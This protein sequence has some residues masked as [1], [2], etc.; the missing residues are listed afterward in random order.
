MIKAKQEL[1]NVKLF[2][3]IMVLGVLFF[4]LP[5]RAD[6]V[7]EVEPNDDREEALTIQAN[8]ETIAGAINGTYAGQHVVRG[9][10]SINDRDWFKVYL[11]KGTNYI[12]CNGFTFDY[13]IE[14]ENGMTI[15]YDTYKEGGFGPKAYEFDVLT[16]GDYYICITGTVNSPEQYLFLIG[17][18]TYSVGFCEMNCEQGTIEMQ[19][20]GKK[21]TA[22][23]NGE[24]V[25]NL[26]KD[27][28]ATSI[29]MK[30]VSA[31]AVNGAAVTNTAKNVS[32]SMP[33][34]SLRVQDIGSLNLPVET[35]WQVEFGYRKVTSFTPVMKVYYAYPV[36]SAMVQ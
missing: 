21:V 28:I 15:F 6:S 18:P 33:S 36:Y 4:S 34:Y 16:T 31:T 23:F 7:N 20:N 17:S 13:H 32:L 14:D 25:T 5:V 2:L 26:P 8:D 27:A 24:S 30:D 10:S 29:T 35:I 11:K 22:T 19:S 3:C 12:T 1:Y 9:Y